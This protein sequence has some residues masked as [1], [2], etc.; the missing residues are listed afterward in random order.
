MYTSVNLTI[1]IIGTFLTGLTAG[2][3]FTWSNAVTPGIGNLSD[4]AYLKAF[5]QMN[6]AILNPTFLLVFMGPSLFHLYNVLFLKSG[7]NTMFWLI[8]AA[9][10]LY[11]LGI[12]LVTIFGNVPL[13][14]MIDKVDLKIISTEA[15]ENLRSTFKN[16]WNTFH[17]I[18]TLSSCISFLL[19]L[20]SIVL[21]SKNLN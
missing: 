19:L 10:A 3:C 6:R 17:L 12:V 11:I 7:S 4:I 15:A 1:L 8:T 13:N 2:L 14:D 9:A 5:Q 18:R 16:K 20:I 21:Y